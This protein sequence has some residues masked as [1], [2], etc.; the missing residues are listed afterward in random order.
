MSEDSAEK[1]AFPEACIQLRER[2]VLYSDQPVNNPQRAIEVMGKVLASL[3]REYLCVV[4]LNAQLHPINYNV[5]SI[6]GLDNTPAPMSNIYKSAILSNASSIILLHNHPSG[7]VEPSEQDLQV[8][9]KVEKVSRLMD[10]QLLDHVIVAGRTG[11][12]YSFMEHGLIEGARRDTGEL[13]EKFAPYHYEKKNQ[14]QEITKKLEDGIRDLQSSDA[15]RHYLDVMSRFH[16]YSM[17][18]CILIAMQKPDASRVAGYTAWEKNFQ[19]H[20]KRGEKGIKIIAPAPYTVSKQRAKTDPLTGK[21]VLN[22]N[23]KPETEVV[24][25][26]VQNF[27][28]TTVF[29]VNQTEEKELPELVYELKADAE[30]Y[31]KFMTAI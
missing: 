29:D 10:I 6:G 26:M 15:Y 21:A 8:T 30:N 24:N 27:K 11:K 9:R 23:G 17:S 18:N 13:G 25:V 1:Y 22:K 20:V 31:S 2:T 3:D 5:V 4:N 16:H 7:V 28:V 19:R 12:R 14:L